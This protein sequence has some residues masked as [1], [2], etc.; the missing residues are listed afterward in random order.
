MRILVVEHDP[1]LN[2]FLQKQFAAEKLA[3]DFAASIEPAKQLLSGHEY[4]SAILDMNLPRGEAFELL[5][6]LRGSRK[7]FSTA[8]LAISDSP[9]DRPQALNLGADEFLLKPFGFLQLLACLRPLLHGQKLQTDS[10]LRLENLELSPRER[11]VTRAGRKI[12]LTPTEFALL[13][14]LLANA[15]QY[16][17]RSEIVRHVWHHNGDP[18]TNIVDVY[19]NYL[20]KKV[21]EPFDSQLIHTVRGVGY[22]LAAPSA[23]RRLA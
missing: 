23:P 5:R 18:L 6:H 1:A 14:Y 11:R 17:T 20:R 19:V 2:A 12:S 8:V 16:V 15:G 22:R 9:G 7:Q 13:E 3:A 21:D 10:M 4:G